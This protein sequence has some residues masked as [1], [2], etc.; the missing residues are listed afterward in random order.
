MIVAQ[1]SAE[2]RASIHCAF[3][4]GDRLWRNQRVIQT[5]M[6]SLDMVVRHVLSNDGSQVLLTKEHDVV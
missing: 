2:T 3:G 4:G 5:L 6:V 1:Q